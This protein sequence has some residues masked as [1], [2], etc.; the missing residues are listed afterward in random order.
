[1]HNENYDKDFRPSVG[2]LQASYNGCFITVTVDGKTIAA[3]FLSLE[4]KFY[5]SFS[6]AEVGGCTWHQIFHELLK[7]QLS[8]LYTVAINQ[9]T[10]LR[11]GQLKDLWYVH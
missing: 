3:E 10:Y 6:I 2:K 4:G 5:T 1:V 8:Y 11:C 7:Q 9:I